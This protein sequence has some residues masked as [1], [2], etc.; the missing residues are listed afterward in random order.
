MR[1]FFR[2]LPLIL[3]ASPFATSQPA[4]ALQIDWAGE[5]R[6]EYN[7]VRNYSLESGE[8]GQINDATR[9]SAGGYYIPHG[10]SNN[11]SF[12]NLFLRLKPR[13]TVN[14]NLYI[15]S[16]WWAG[17]P[18]FGIF[19]NAVPYNI[20]QRQWYSNQSRGSVISAQR[21]WAEIDSDVGVFEIGR[22]PLDWGLGLIWN[23]GDGIWGK[24]TAAK[25]ERTTAYG[26]PWDRYESTGD[27]IRLV[28]KFGSFS[29]SPA[30][31]QY[32]SGNNIGGAGQYNTA[33]TVYSPTVGGGGVTEY[34]FALKY[35]NLDEDLEGGVNF[36]RRIGQAAQDTHAGPGSTGGGAVPANTPVGMSFN[37]WDLY[38]KKKLGRFT[39]GGEVPIV[40]GSLGSGSFSSYAVAVEVDWKMSESWDSSIRAG[41]VPGQPGSA[42]AVTD[43]FKAFYLNPNYKL[44]LIMFNYQLA[45]FAGPNTLNNP[46]TTPSALRSPY[47][48]PITNANYL[49]VGAAYHTDKWD[50]H[51]NWVYAKANETAGAGSAFFWNDAQR[52]YVATGAGAGEQS[53]SIGLEMDYGAT[54]QWDDSFTFGLDFGFFFPGDYWAYSNT[55]TQNATDTVFAAVA[56]VGIAF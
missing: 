41:H 30:F 47:D 53:T 4:S 56:R 43:Q 22:A 3:L 29:F 21:F 50:F 11:A 8:A 52:T 23:R 46:N 17:D 6:S 40:S 33:G 48:N 49:N 1:N 45:N 5:F 18:V 44:G 19:G 25:G 39:V 13:V 34:S 54:F 7:F 9:A 12:Q 10:G 32:S 37:T 36:I 27:Q 16:E 31:I 14:D 26:R 51:T 24:R 28:S 42:T 15:Y 2:Y 20:D 55:A 35:E 38:G